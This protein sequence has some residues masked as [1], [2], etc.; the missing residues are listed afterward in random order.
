MILSDAIAVSTESIIHDANAMNTTKK[1]LSHKDYPSSTTPTPP[2]ANTQKN[3]GGGRQK[4]EKDSQDK[5]P[6][7]FEKG[8]KH[9]RLCRACPKDIS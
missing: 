1:G 9:K 8:H 4:Q 3:K 5:K 2:K 7:L 6:I